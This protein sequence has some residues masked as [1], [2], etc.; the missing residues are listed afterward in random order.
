MRQLKYHEQKLLKKV[1]F[2]EWK[3]TNTTREQMVT[4]KYLLKERDEYK[5][6]N[7]IVGMIRKLTETLSRLKDGDAT[8]LVISKRLINLLHDAGLI[9]EKTLVDCTKINVSSFCERRLPMVMVKKR[10]IETFVHA[11]EFVQHGHV[12]V[13]TKTINDPSIIISRAMEEFVTWVDTSKIKK[14]IC[15]FNGERDDYGR[16]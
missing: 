10:M 6:Y 9:S 8:K 15:E 7:I 5:K 16:E 13:G 4:S 1:N 12:R 14:K 3:R 11:D 2:L